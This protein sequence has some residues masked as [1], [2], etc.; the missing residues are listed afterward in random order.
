MCGIAGFVLL[1]QPAERSLVQY[2]RPDS[3]SRPDDEGLAVIAAAHAP[4][5]HHRSLDRPPADVQ[6]GRYGGSFNGEI[7]HIGNCART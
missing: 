5:E 6:R 1:D 3:P 7:Y 4:P 2:V